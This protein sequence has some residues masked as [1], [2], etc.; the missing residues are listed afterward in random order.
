MYSASSPASV[1]QKGVEVA[2]GASPPN[3]TVFSVPHNGLGYWNLPATVNM[4]DS[5]NNLNWGSLNYANS[6][7]TVEGSIGLPTNL[8]TTCFASKLFN[9]DIVFVDC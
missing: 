3:T 9:N 8:G 2:S 7:P 1:Q 4:L 6:V 5:E